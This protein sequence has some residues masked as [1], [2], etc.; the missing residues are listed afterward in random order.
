MAGALTLAFAAPAYADGPASVKVTACQ[1]GD[2]P[3]NRA[4]T[5]E[6]RMNTVKGAVRMAQRFKLVSYTGA[7]AQA[8]EVKNPKLS[9]WHSSDRGVKRFVYAQ[10][11]KPLA[12]GATYGAVVNYRWLDANGKVIRRAERKSGKCIQDGN[13]PNLV[14]SSVHVTPGPTP[15]TAVY[16]I[17]VT[18]AGKGDAGPFDIAL[19]VDGGLPNSQQVNGLKAGTSMTQKLT[20]PLCKR[21]RAVIDRSRSLVETLKD[22]N[23]LRS[24]C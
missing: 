6:G 24:R 1:T 18:N 14:L 9:A 15:D 4:A 5:F 23:E 16:A 10:T 19:I 17:S 2:E 7:P 8:Q 20:G 13:L 21:F 12:E 3:A 11:V 22:D